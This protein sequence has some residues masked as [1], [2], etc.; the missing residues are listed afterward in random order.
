MA[1]ASNVAVEATPSTRNLVLVS[2]SLELDRR[3][4]A[5]LV[6]L[7]IEVLSRLGSRDSQPDDLG[8]SPK[9]SGRQADLMGAVEAQT[10]DPST[11]RLYENLGITFAG[12]LI[13]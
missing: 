8:R 10:R 4:S 1:F 2:R 13:G 7:Q 3:H 6:R 12:F 9:H 5:T 11:Q